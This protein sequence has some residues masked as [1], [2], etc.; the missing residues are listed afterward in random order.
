MTRLRFLGAPSASTQMQ[1]LHGGGGRGGSLVSEPEAFS[2]STP[3]KRAQ[4]E[5]SEARPA[6]D[7]RNA[8]LACPQA[9][10]GTAG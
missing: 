7:G 4:A 2:G 6:V 3:P 5:R 9:G 1:R 10:R 8:G